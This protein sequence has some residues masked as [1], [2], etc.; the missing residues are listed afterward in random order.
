MARIDVPLRENYWA[1]WNPS[2]IVR[3]TEDIHAVRKY[4]ERAVNLFVEVD[5]ELFYPEKTQWAAVKMK[6]AAFGELLSGDNWVWPRFPDGFGELPDM[7]TV[8]PQG[9]LTFYKEERVGFWEPFIRLYKGL[10]ESV[11]FRVFL[12]IVLPS[13]LAKGGELA[14]L[15]DAVDKTSE[16]ADRITTPW[17]DWVD[18]KVRILDDFFNDYWEKVRNPFLRLEKA[19]YDTVQPWVDDYRSTLDKYNTT[20]DR[21]ISTQN[22]AVQILERPVLALDKNIGVPWRQFTGRI[23]QQLSDVAN[24]LAV[25]GIDEGEKIRTEYQRAVSVVTLDYNR[26]YDDVLFRIQ[27]QKVAIDQWRER[28][29]GPVAENL[30]RITPIVDN[31]ALMVEAVEKDTRRLR[32]KPLQE[33]LTAHPATV[34]SGIENAY[35][36]DVLVEAPPPRIEEEVL[37]EIEWWENAVDKADENLY[38]DSEGVPLQPAIGEK[39]IWT[40]DPDKITGEVV[41]V[42]DALRQPGVENLNDVRASTAIWEIGIELGYI[43]DITM[44][45]EEPDKYTWALKGVGGMLSLHWGLLAYANYEYALKGYNFLVDEPERNIQFLQELESS[46]WNSIKWMASKVGASGV[47]GQPPLQEK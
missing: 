40:V 9:Y 39:G 10:G 43:P 47:P 30:G 38:V 1:N 25:F 2:W 8:S 11:L 4:I 37:P 33:T 35:S 28:I 15:G 27:A 23:D 31:V 29:F 44:P 45:V 32:Q 6:N 26:K 7:V 17:L 46:F 36:S 21:I 34:V 16:W 41:Q 22:R 20:F 18:A 5:G 14:F 13:M 42:T 24:F 3:K 12:A 19:F